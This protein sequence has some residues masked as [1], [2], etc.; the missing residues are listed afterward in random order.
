MAVIDRKKPEK[1]L[2]VSI[3]KTGGRNASGRIT[4]RHRGG[5]LRK[6]WRQIDFAQ[7]HL[8]VK[9]SRN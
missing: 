9:G 6:L 3:R 1:S 4:I 5:G 7:E 2:L 8:N